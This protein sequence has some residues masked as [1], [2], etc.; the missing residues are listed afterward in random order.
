MKSLEKQSMKTSLVYKSPHLYTLFLR[1]LHGKNYRA[2]YQAVSKE[3]PDGVEVLDVCCGDCALYTRE[4]RNRVSYTG[5]DVN[6]HF[7]GNARKKSIK[8]LQLDVEKDDLPRADY[9][10]MQGSLNQFIPRHKLMVDKLLRAARTKVIISEPIR[11]LATSNNIFL[12]FIARRSTDPGTGHKPYRFNKETFR[13]F[14]EEN[15]KAQTEKFKF[16][17]P[18]KR[19]MMVILNTKR[20]KLEAE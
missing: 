12:S 14:F 17:L 16:I 4:L 19:E 11:N 18:V 5:V 6:P 2:R 7:L 20:A 8:F 1:V 3:I 13:E 9:V 15:Y 10:I